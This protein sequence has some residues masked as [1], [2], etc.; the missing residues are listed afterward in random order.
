MIHTDSKHPRIL[1]QWH[2]E[3]FDKMIFRNLDANGNSKFASN[4]ETEIGKT[5]ENKLEFVLVA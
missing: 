1:P 3:I 2:M 5:Y 4:I